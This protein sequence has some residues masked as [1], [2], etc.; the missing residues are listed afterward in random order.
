MRLES[1]LIDNVVQRCGCVRKYTS[2]NTSIDVSL[3]EKHYDCLPYDIQKK[4]VITS[5]SD[6]E[7]ISEHFKEP[8][9]QDKEEYPGIQLTEQELWED[10]ILYEDEREYTGNP[11]WYDNP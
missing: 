5:E 3:C 7:I 9:V 1:L 4:T 2:T 10:S 8:E 6:M 11:R